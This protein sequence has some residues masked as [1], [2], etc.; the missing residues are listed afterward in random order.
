MVLTPLGISVI[1]GIISLDVTACWQ[2]MIS[3]P[4]IIGPLVGWLC[5]DLLLGL[6]LGAIMELLWINTLPLGASIPVDAAATTV[7]ATATAG[8]VRQWWSGPV[9][10]SL[11][12]GIAFALPFGALFNRLDIFTR[13]YNNKLVYIADNLAKISALNRIQFLIILAIVLIFLKYFLF[14]FICVH[15]GIYFFR[16]ILPYVPL[17]VLRGLEQARILFMALG[18]AVVLDTFKLRKPGRERNEQSQ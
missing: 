8:Y 13:R 10:V 9:G 7:V 16:T 5:G 2:I 17:F 14:Y 11:M 12:L 15:L 3:R 1:A 18:F 6:Y 4:I